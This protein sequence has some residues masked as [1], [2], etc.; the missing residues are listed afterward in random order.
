MLSFTSCVPTLS[1]GPGVCG[2]DRDRPPVAGLLLPLVSGGRFSFIV[3]LL[4][5]FGTKNLNKQRSLKTFVGAVDDHTDVPSCM[6]SIRTLW[7]VY[8][9]KILTVW[10][11]E[12]LDVCKAT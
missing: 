2:G 12:E 11:H 9:C 5:E 8:T 1:Q 7:D 6:K 3:V 4:N 10:C